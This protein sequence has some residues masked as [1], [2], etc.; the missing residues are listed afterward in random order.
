M[1]MTVILVVMMS[2]VMT[3]K[4]VVMTVGVGEERRS[5]VKQTQV[6]GGAVHSC[7]AR[8]DAS[9]SSSKHLKH[10]PRLPSP[11]FQQSPA[12]KQAHQSLTF[13]SL[14]QAPLSILL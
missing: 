13:P 8:Y 14:Q 5:K 3:V 4:T 1:V 12:S 11:F 6:G 10:L 9:F 7:L 2:M